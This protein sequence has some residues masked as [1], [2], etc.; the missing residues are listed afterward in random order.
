[1]LEMTCRFRA[2]TGGK[3][4]TAPFVTAIQRSSI[5]TRAASVASATAS[6]ATRELIVSPSR[7]GE[8]CERW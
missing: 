8:H 1:M 6:R 5:Y 7:H 3:T 4:A 2:T